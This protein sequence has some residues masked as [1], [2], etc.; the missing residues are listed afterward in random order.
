M[1]DESA[2][3]SSA[4]ANTF[5]VHS[6]NGVKVIPSQIPILVGSA[7]ESIQFV[8]LPLLTSRCR[9]NLLSENVQR[10]RRYLQRVQVSVADRSYECGTFDQ[11]ISSCGEKPPFRYRTDPMAG[12]AYTLQ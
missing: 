11:L 1:M 10:R 9:H 12:S 3:P 5:G 2:T 6:Q 7:K 8:F 4:R